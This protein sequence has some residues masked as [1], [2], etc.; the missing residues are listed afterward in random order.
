V[1]ICEN[2]PIQ[3]F[4]VHPISLTVIFY[5][6]NAPVSLLED[7]FKRPRCAHYAPR[8]SGGRERSRIK[9][10]IEGRAH[11]I[12]DRTDTWWTSFI[13]G[14]AQFPVRT[15][16]MR[17]REDS[18][19]SFFSCFP[20]NCVGFFKLHPCFLFVEAMRKNLFEELS[21]GLWRNAQYQAE[22]STGISPPA[23]PLPPK[24]NNPSK[25]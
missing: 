11:Q 14:D 20:V 6:Q 2:Y 13:S 4:N 25:R 3:S 8:D 7:F 21:F 1:I 23:L 9:P 16:P 5:Y 10:L 18:G 15:L 24:C 17:G 22:R 12:H 19:S